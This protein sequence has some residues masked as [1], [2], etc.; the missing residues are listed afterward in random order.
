[1]EAGTSTIE[2]GCGALVLLELLDTW[3]TEN[4]SIEVS[5]EGRGRG[6]VKSSM[7]RSCVWPW[8]LPGPSNVV[9]VWAL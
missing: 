2:F 4:V 7:E 8:F 5:I 1:M 9:P 6:G 3:S